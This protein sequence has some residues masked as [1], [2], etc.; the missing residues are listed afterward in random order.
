MKVPFPALLVAA[1][2]PLVVAAE[3]GSDTAPPKPGPPGE[4]DAASHVRRAVAELFL[5]SVADTP[6]E[7]MRLPDDASSAQIREALAAVT[8]R[9]DRMRAAWDEDRRR[10]ESLLGPLDDL[11]SDSAPSP[12]AKPEPGSDFVRH[13]I[14]WVWISTNS[15]KADAGFWVSKSEMRIKQAAD[16][17][18]K[19]PETHAGYDELRKNLEQQA[20]PIP[21]PDV[22]ALRDKAAR[23][24]AGNNWANVMENQGLIIFRAEVQSK[25]NA[26]IAQERE[27]L[28]KTAEQG[29]LKPLESYPKAVECVTTSQPEEAKGFAD[30]AYAKFGGSNPWRFRL[31]REAEWTEYQKMTEKLEGLGKSDFS[32]WVMGSDGSFKVVDKNWKGEA[33]TPPAPGSASFRL[34]FAAD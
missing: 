18:I 8:Q 15:S 23:A 16:H 31:P 3:T 21:Q 4:C 11:L 14:Q 25:A 32:E 5:E 13:G 33:T 7:D 26:M 20:I 1:I 17:G 29:R 28:R 12:E 27:R 19:L 30:A 10:I 2:L 24:V 22:A 34:V 6:A 9:M